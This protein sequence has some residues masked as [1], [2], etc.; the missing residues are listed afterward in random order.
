MNVKREIPGRQVAEVLAAVALLLWRIWDV[1]LD[2]LW[3][4]WVAV[5]ALFWIAAVA[6]GDSPRRASVLAAVAAGLMGIYAWGQ[7]P[8]ALAL[9]G[10]R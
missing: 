8:H 2:R 5:L 10:L 1:P 6:L 9:F 4:D 7:A 3:R